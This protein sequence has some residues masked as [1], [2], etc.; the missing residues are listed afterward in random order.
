MRTQIRCSAC[1][2][3]TVAAELVLKEFVEFKQNKYY[4]RRVRNSDVTAVTAGN[5]EHQN[6]TH[7]DD[8]WDTT[9]DPLVIKV[10]NI[11]LGVSEAMFQMILE[12]KRYGGGAVRRV[13]FN[14]SAHSAVVEFEDRAGMFNHQ[15]LLLCSVSEFSLL[16]VQCSMFH[17]FLG[18]Q[19]YQI[20][21]FSIV[22]F[23]CRL[24]KLCKINCLKT[25][26]TVALMK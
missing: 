16:Y 14:E 11:P 12:N 1:L 18:S 5:D 24:V 8:S 13:E 15:S 2:I 4:I 9:L 10:T 3:V 21:T 23:N 22:K 17:L 6:V 25:I 7:H 19:I 20:L 26:A